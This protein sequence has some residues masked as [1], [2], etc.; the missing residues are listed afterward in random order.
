MA[1]YE[2]YTV[3][4][5]IMKLENEKLL[6]ILK[7]H[8]SEKP[9]NFNELNNPR[10]YKIHIS[11]NFEKQTCLQQQSPDVIHKS[12]R[13]LHSFTCYAEYNNKKSLSHR[14]IRSNAYMCVVWVMQNIN[15]GARKYKVHSVENS[16]RFMSLLFVSCC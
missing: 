1:V 5:A 11:L 4:C 15:Y 2:Y 16:A 9:Y 6:V 8:N 14:S 13:Y 12:K 3:T 10:L 7:W